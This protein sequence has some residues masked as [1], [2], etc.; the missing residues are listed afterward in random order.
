MKA[1]RAAEQGKTQMAALVFL[2]RAVGDLSLPIR[3]AEEWVLPADLPGFREEVE[4]QIRTFGAFI[5]EYL[6]LHSKVLDPNTDRDTVQVLEVE[7]SDLRKNLH[8]LGRIGK[9]PA[10]ADSGKSTSQIV[11]EEIRRA[12]AGGDGGADFVIELEELRKLRSGELK[13]GPRSA[14]KRMQP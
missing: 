2:S 5:E 13:I 10:K 8:F 3:I 1:K 4:K 11:R 6:A 14:S 7:L 12:I 9:A